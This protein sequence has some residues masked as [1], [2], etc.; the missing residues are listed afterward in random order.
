MNPQ[1]FL[2][3]LTADVQ[4][5][6]IPSY[7]VFV[8]FALIAIALGNSSPTIFRF[9]GNRFLPKQGQE[10]YK[11][12]AEP[13]SGSIKTAATL[14]LLN[15]S[16]VWLRQ[17]DAVYEL[18]RPFMELA[19]TIAVAWLISRIFRQ[20]VRGYGITTLQKMGLEADELILPFEAVVNVLIG[21][22]A[23][24]A[25]AQSQNINLFGLI[26]SLGVA[27][28]AVGFAA[29]SALSQIIGTVVLYLDRPFNKGDYIRMPNGLYGRVESIGLRST[30]IRTAAKSTLAIVPNSQMAD[31]EIENITRGKKVMVLLYLD[32]NRLLEDEEQ[33]MVTQVIKT[34]T[35]AITG[36]DPG[37]TRIQL[38]TPEDRDNSRARV[39]FFI[40]GSSENS[41]QLRKRLLE[42]ANE[43]ISKQLV[44]YDLHFTTQDPTIYVES[45]VTV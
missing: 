36:I 31:S 2:D 43:N 41:I 35:D 42:I 11:T 34:S 25:F 3:N 33:A 39:T 17:Y 10:I 15:L 44:R 30:K 23:A 40:L 14:I 9:I 27:A 1:Q 24:I 26:A 38:L 19:V 4:L 7:L 21:I 12:I 37:S 22:F 29:Q 8:G 16:L 5:A 28:T 13:I 20:L 45:P 32:F 18:I 6:S